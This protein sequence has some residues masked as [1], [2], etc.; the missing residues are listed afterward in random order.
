[1]ATGKRTVGYCVYPGCENHVRGVLLPTREEPFH[2]PRCERPGKLEWERGVIRGDSDIFNEVRVDYDFDPLAGCYRRTARVRDESIL[3]EHNTF[4]FQSPFIR[5]K[6]VAFKAAEVI[7]RQFNRY[8]GPVRASDPGQAA[9][10][11]SVLTR[12]DNGPSDSSVI[13]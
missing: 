7:L 9:R 13:V 2:C 5:T 12:E 1:M 4:T 6:E 11:L 8:K 3:T 10:H